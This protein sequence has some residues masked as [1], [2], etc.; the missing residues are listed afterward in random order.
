MLV[1]NKFKKLKTCDS[2]YFR[3]KSHFEEDGTKNYLV[4]QPMYRYF[5]RVAGVGTGNYIY[6][7]KSEGLSDENITGPTTS[8]YK[9]NTQ[10]SYYGTKTRVEFRGKCLKQDKLYLIKKGSNNRVLSMVAIQHRTLS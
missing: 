7:W 3:G 6:F 5:K 9:L 10:L 1:E 2:V 8:D 4:F